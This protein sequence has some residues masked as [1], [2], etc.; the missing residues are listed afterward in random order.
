MKTQHVLG[1]EN[2]AVKLRNSVLRTWGYNA[3]GWQDDWRPH[4]M[5][6]LKGPRITCP[7]DFLVTGII[8]SPQSQGHWCILLLPFSGTLFS[9]E[10]V[11]ISFLG[12]CTSCAKQVN[13][14]E[15]HTWF[16]H[17]VDYTHSIA[18]KRKQSSNSESFSFPFGAG[19][20][21]SGGCMSQAITNAAKAEVGLDRRIMQ[22]Y[23]LIYQ[24]SQLG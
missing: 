19:D 16:T 20:D 10:W 24:S 23:P 7:W 3:D 8:F 2:E 9:L 4:A 13:N 6:L 14:I 17:V 12:W 5:R 15:R 11:I 21:G 1:N 18:T 22:S